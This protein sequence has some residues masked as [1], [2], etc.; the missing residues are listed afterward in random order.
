MTLF[1]RRLVGGVLRLPQ[2]H[3][4]GI[5]LRLQAQLPQ[6][7]SRVERQLRFQVLG[8]V[9]QRGEKVVDLVRSVLASRPLSWSRVLRSNLPFFRFRTL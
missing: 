2:I 9:L 4:R 7:G 8:E 5:G 6:G 1:R 3:L